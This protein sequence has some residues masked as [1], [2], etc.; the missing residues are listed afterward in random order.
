MANTITARSPNPPTEAPTPIPIWA[1]CDKP[2]AGGAAVPEL[3]VGLVW[4]CPEVDTLELL[5]GAGV[6]VGPDPSKEVVSVDVTVV[7]A[8]APL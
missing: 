1:L 6:V 3:L 4:L 7:V 2:T 5:I 8:L